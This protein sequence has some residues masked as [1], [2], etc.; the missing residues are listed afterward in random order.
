MTLIIFADYTISTFSG[1]SY[2]QWASADLD[3]CLYVKEQLS[4]ITAL[5]DVMHSHLVYGMHKAVH[6]VQENGTLTLN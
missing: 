4:Q 5:L 6:R 3:E 1:A 2:F